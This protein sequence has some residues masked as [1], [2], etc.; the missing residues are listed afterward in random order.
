LAVSEVKTEKGCFFAGFLT[1]LSELKKA[2]SALEKEKRTLEGILLSSVDP[3]LVIEPNGIIQRVNAATVRMFGFEDH[4]LIGHN[5]TILMPQPYRDQHD[6]YLKRYLATGIKRVIGIGREVV[7]LRKDGTTL[8]LH[9]AVSE[10]VIDGAYCFAGFLT[11]LSQ[12]KNAFLSADKAKSMFL[13]NMSHEIRTPMNGIMGMISLLKDSTLDKAGKSYIDIC[14]RSC[15]SLLAVLN[16]ILL[17]SKADAG[18]IDLD[19]VP[20]NLNNMV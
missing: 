7:G 3:I 5:V 20:F 8:P 12:L 2:Q 15:E 11:D 19:N 6:G 10:V 13:A 17:Y 18:A 9:L 16:D 4:E 1:D 14:M